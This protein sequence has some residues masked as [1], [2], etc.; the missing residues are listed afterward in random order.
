MDRQTIDNIVLELAVEAAPGRFRQVPLVPTTRLKH[1][2][3]LDSIAMLALL[4]RL[5][6]RFGIDLAAVDVGVTLAQLVTVGDLLAVA[7]S[8]IEGADTASADAA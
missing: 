7:H 3:G 8:V 5:E 1:D 4:F 2:L 6:E